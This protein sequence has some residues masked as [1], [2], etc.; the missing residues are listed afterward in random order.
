MA[1]W[2]EPSPELAYLICCAAPRYA[3]SESRALAPLGATKARVPAPSAASTAPSLWRIKLCVIRGCL[4]R[5]Q[6]LA[7]PGSRLPRRIGQSALHL[8][9]ITDGRTLLERRRD[10]ALFVGDR[11]E[12]DGLAFHR[13]ERMA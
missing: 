6:L 5:V 12:A 4:A 10:A 8:L 13:G 1:C 2:I 7:T 9:D 3:I 11:L